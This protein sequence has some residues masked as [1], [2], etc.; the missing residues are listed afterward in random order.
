M[1]NFL[2]FTFVFAIT[3]IGII[4]SLGIWIWAIVDCIKSDLKTS[5]KLIWAIIIVMLNIIGAIL[6]FL[7]KESIKGKEKMTKKDQLTKS[8]NNHILAGVCGGLGEHFNIDPTV[9]RLL[10]VLLIIFSAG[11]G[12]LLYLIAML[13]IPEENEIK[14]KDYKKNKKSNTASTIAIAIAAIF[15]VFILSVSLI[16]IVGITQFTDKDISRNIAISHIEGISSS[17]R[18]EMIVKDYIL[19]SNNYKEY[20]GE[21]LFCTSI[22]ESDENICPPHKDPYGI[23]IYFPK[24]YTIKCKFDSKNSLA[25]GFMVEATTIDDKVK[26]INFNM[27]TED[28]N[29]KEIKTEKDCKDSGYE[30]LYPELVGGPIQCHTNSGIINVSS[31]PVLPPKLSNMTHQTKPICIDKCGDGVCQ[32]IVCL[33]E[34]CPCAE[35]KT[36]CSL[37]CL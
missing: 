29:Q 4:I 10:W 36:T 17:Q 12:L 20:S 7:L 34:G 16:A 5:E 37:D 9:I 25:Y 30:V 27:I 2:G 32:G 15:I 28:K 14:N 33:G 26:E 1:E 23:K 19:S 31:S 6:Y 18:A 11:T 3:F 24:C 13:I 35:D 22:R 8:K 21:N